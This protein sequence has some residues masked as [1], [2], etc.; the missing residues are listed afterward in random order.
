MLSSFAAEADDRFVFRRRLL[1]LVIFCVAILNTALLVPSDKFSDS[2]LETAVEVLAVIVGIFMSV[3]CLMWICGRVLGGDDRGE[4]YGIRVDA[5][6]VSSRAE[7]TTTYDNL[8][9]RQKRRLDRMRS[10]A[11]GHLLVGFSMKLRQENLINNSNEETAESDELL[12]HRIIPITDEEEGNCDASEHNS[13]T[14]VMIHQHHDSDDDLNSSTRE[15]PNSCAICL[16]EYEVSDNVSWSANPQCP[17]VF[18]EKCITKWF[19]SLGRLQTICGVSL[20]DDC[21]K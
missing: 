10:D 5:E 9:R 11:I 21:P 1:I 6:T 20:E 18:H 3:V 19:L 7:S 14:L 2:F 13:N 8:S 15:V 4:I 16:T 12:E 17:H